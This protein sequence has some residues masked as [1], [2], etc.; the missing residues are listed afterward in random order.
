MGGR[1]HQIGLIRALFIDAD[2]SFDTNAGGRS[3]L[4][5]LE[6]GQPD[7][8][9]APST[10]LTVNYGFAEVSLQGTGLRHIIRDGVL[11]DVVGGRIDTMSDRYGDRLFFAITVLDL[12]AERLF[13]IDQQTKTVEI[14]NPMVGETDLVFAAGFSDTLNGWSGN[15][16]LYGAGG[17]GVLV[18]GIG[19]DRLYGGPGDD[20]FV[21]NTAL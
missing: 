11:L 6:S 20:K 19:R 18:G 4:P 14:L 17:D 15:D 21:F 13:H 3:I 5:G 9:D 16:T 8:F 7:D 12:S 2:G 10:V 1:V